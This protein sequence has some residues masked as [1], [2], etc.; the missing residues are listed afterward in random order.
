MA[1]RE[2][3]V[4]GAN[5]VKPVLLLTKDLVMYRMDYTAF[6]LFT[7]RIITLPKAITNS[8]ATGK[9]MKQPLNCK[10]IL[11]VFPATE[12][13]QVHSTVLASHMQ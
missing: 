8:T 5:V 7:K 3:K 9:F 13:L 4:G 1:N 6:P 11:L 10:L 2:E 12:S